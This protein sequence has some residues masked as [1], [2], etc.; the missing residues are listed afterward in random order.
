MKIH[1]TEAESNWVN[2]AARALQMLSVSHPETSRMAHLANK[3]AYQTDGLTTVV[4]F[5]RP[6]RALL[7]EVAKVRFKS[8]DL[9]PCDE[10]EIVAGLIKKL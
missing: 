8:L 10:R 2:Q 1:L 4:N 6:Q 3:I 7:S 9:I 5:T